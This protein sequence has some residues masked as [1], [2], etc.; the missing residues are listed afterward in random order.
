MGSCEGTKGGIVGQLADLRLV[1]QVLEPAACDCG[2]EVEDRSGRGGDP[3]G[4]VGR[5]LRR[6]AGAVD[7]D[8]GA[9]ASG[10]P[11]GDVDDV[12]LAALQPHSAAA[13]AW[14]SA[15]SGPHAS[16]AAIHRP[17]RPSTVWP[18]AYTPR[19]TGCSRPS[20]TRCSIDRADRPSSASCSRA[21]TPCWRRARA[22]IAR[23]TGCG[24]TRLHMSSAT[25]PTPRGWQG[26][27]HSGPPE[28]QQ[29][30]ATRGAEQQQRHLHPLDAAVP[31][32]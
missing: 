11:G 15:A 4:V 13:E 9:A 10:A 30:S 7:A 17:L 22:A 6:D 27:R 5:R 26:T 18:T 3:D 8:A 32:P 31:N 21:M 1:E 28:T 12:R 29:F 23:S 24:P 2:G 14:L 20:A 25:R 19:W 16:T